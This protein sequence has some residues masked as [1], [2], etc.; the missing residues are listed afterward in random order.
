MISNA[1]L[2][3]DP[4]PTH[5]VSYRRINPGDPTDSLPKRLRPGEIIT[6]LDEK[7]RL[8]EA[9]KNERLQ[10]VCFDTFGNKHRYG[11]WVVWEDNALS[12]YAEPG[13]GWGAV[14]E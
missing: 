10:P 14:D 5:L 12:N 1:Y 9:T 2:E 11:A 3:R 7:R 4:P 8:V 6:F 13:P